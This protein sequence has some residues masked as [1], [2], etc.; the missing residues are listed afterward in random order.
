MG[1]NE[2]ALTSRELEVLRLVAEGLTDC[3]V[4]ERLVISNRTVNR[5]LSNILPRPRCRRCLHDSPGMG[6][7]TCSQQAEGLHELYVAL[8]PSFITKSVR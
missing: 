7:I 5:Q 3:K 8:E 6:L 4:A 2:R 1:K